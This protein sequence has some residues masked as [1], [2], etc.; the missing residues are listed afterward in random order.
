VGVSNFHTGSTEEIKKSIQ[1]LLSGMS[2]AFV[3]SVWGMLLS[4]WFGI[5]EKLIFNDI[6][7][8][9][10]KLCRVL[11][12]E[13][14]ISR[15]YE[16]EILKNNQKELLEELYEKQSNLLEEFFVIKTENKEIKPSYI[17]AKIL[18]NF[19]QEI[20]TLNSLKEFY[21]N[22]IKK[23]FVFVN[24]NTEE[25]LPSS[26]FKEMRNEMTEQTKS[27]KSFSSD[28]ADGIKISTETIGAFGDSII[29][30]I[31][32]PFRTQLTPSLEKLELAIDKIRE[33]KEESSVSFIEK[34]VSELQSSL[35]GMGS[36]LSQSLSSST[37]TQL[38]NLANIVSQAGE[39]LNQI[40]NK[41]SD[42]VNI[43]DSQIEKT[44]LTLEEITETSK[45]NTET[46]IEETQN[47]FLNLMDKLEDGL[48]QQQ[49]LVKVISSSMTENA[50]KATVFMS[51]VVKNSTND[52]NDSINLLQDNIKNIIDLE[53]ENSVFM[54]K[55]FS[56]SK[57]LFEKSFIVTDK[58][59]ISILNVNSSIEKIGNLVNGIDNTSKVFNN[60]GVNLN[61][62]IDKF[63]KQSIQLIE[64]NS[65]TLDK[66]QEAL[67]T[68][69]EVADDYS[70]KF[71]V[72][73]S[74]LTGIFG[75]I[76]TGLINYQ[77]TTRKSLDTYLGD[78]SSKLSTA[79]QHLS[80]SVE[81][82]SE[83]L[84]DI[85]EIAEKLNSK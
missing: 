48:S 26:I 44:K 68:S 39:S 41:I 23:Y 42:M 62:I 56:D 27:L 64:N 46:Q 74:G 28:L 30:V 18:Q 21:E 52:F 33:T 70:N 37:V 24:E 14:L 10:N 63:K 59:N 85:A 75:E 67:I 78:F 34:V 53:K 76:Q 22:T 45:K 82:M 57:D 55:L 38:E 79:S 4:L 2:T 72:I 5:I 60:I 80:G 6:N 7:K 65:D 71:E 13:F 49:N 66:L 32:K 11:D 17:L 61:D 58:L 83:A 73:Q 51:Q 16:I 40:P 47:I 36:E 81:S 31:E 1:L 54:S 19:E 3:S 15:A 77:E 29:E 69:Q 12:K 9:V 8:N 50:Q 20:N 84:D 43:L 35:Q 25:V